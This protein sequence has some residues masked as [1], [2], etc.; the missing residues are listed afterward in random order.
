MVSMSLL[1]TEFKLKEK[2]VSKLGLREDVVLL[3]LRGNCSVCFPLS[4]SVCSPVS[5]D[6]PLKE[7]ADIFL[8]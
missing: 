6:T 2:Q 3:T 8:W 5:Q 4:K 7:R 1:C